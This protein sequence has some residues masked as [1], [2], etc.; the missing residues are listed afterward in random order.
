MWVVLDEKYGL[1]R[2]LGQRGMGAVYLAK[3]YVGLKF[4]HA[5]VHEQRGVRRTIQTRG[6]RGRTLAPS[7]RRGRNGLWFRA[8]GPRA[9]GQIAAELNCRYRGTFDLYQLRCGG[10]AAAR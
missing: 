9:S 2:R 8:S 7:E 3:G 1:E 5:A 6:A 4:D 10:L